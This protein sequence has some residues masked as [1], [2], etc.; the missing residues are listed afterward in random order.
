MDNQERFLVV[1]GETS[2][3]FLNI[4]KVSD[5]KLCQGADLAS[6][7]TQYEIKE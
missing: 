4:N 6:L 2:K 7:I 3:V 5:C 1:N